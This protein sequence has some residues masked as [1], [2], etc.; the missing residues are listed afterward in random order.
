MISSTVVGT[1]PN[2][3]HKNLVWALD[4]EAGGNL[5]KNEDFKKMGQKPILDT[6]LDLE[7]I[8]NSCV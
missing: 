6:Q 5:V 8:P 7:S 2:T 4:P 1:T 3:T